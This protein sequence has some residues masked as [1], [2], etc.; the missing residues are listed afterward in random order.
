MGY[1]AQFYWIKVVMTVIRYALFLDELS[2][3][4]EVKSLA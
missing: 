2:L 4:D 1:F 3:L